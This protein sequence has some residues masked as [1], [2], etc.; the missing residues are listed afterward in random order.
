[1]FNLLSNSLKFTENGDYNYRCIVEKDE[2]KDKNFVIISISDSGQ[3]ID[4]EILPRLFNKFVSKSFE[5][6]GL[7]LFISKSIINSHCGEIWAFN[8]SDKGATFCFKIPQN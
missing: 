2:V 7:G 3:G 6:T 5:G 4:P 1:M 8:N